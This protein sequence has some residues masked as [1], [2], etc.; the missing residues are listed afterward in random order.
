[1]N[2]N[3]CPYCPYLID[4]MNK[5]E[6]INTDRLYFAGMLESIPKFILRHKEQ[7]KLFI[8]SFEKKDPSLLS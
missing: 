2:E 4:I 6:K 8:E 1:M 7:I 3:E 5:D